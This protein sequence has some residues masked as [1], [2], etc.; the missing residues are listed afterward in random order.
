MG[1]SFR[2]LYCNPR[3]RGSVAGGKI[4]SLRA[5]ASSFE[6]GV[7]VCQSFGQLRVSP[8]NINLSS[9]LVRVARP[10]FELFPYDSNTFEKLGYPY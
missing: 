9:E 1:D 3:A 7:P 2:V 6:L 10:S 8:E 4:T 5:E